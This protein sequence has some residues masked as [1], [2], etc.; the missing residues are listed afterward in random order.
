MCR[1]DEGWASP[2]RVL[3]R[4][5]RWRKLRGE[6]AESSK[7]SRQFVVKTLDFCKKIFVKS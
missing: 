1:K 6:E 5:S 4:L 3:P 7:V 2:G